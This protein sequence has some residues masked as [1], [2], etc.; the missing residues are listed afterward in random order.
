MRSSNESPVLMNKS[1]PRVIL[2]QLNVPGNIPTVPLAA[3]YLKAMAFKAGLFQDVDI[4]VLSGSLNNVAGDS[5]VVSYILEK[6]PQIIGFSCYVWNL[7]RSLSIINQIKSRLPKVR[8]ICGGTEVSSQFRKIMFNRNIDI[9]ARGEGE[10]TFVEL[11]KNSLFNIPKLQ[12]IKGIVFRENG[13]M[14]VTAER[15]QIP[16]VNIIPSP[17]LLGFIDTKEYGKIM[18]E[19]YRGCIER[20]SYCN[21]RR[22][23]R[24]IRYF[25]E[26]RIKDEIRLAREKNVECDI[27]DT[28]FNLPDNLTRLSKFI[29]EINYDKH[30]K[31]R[32]EGRAEFINKKTIGHLTKCNVVHINIGLQ[33]TNQIALRNVNRWFN[34]ELFIRGI[35]L[36]KKAKIPFRLDLIIGLPGDGL[37]SIKEGIRFVAKY[38]KNERNYFDILQIPPDVELRRQAKKFKLKYLKTQPYYV[39]STK[40]ISHREF[41]KIFFML[42]D[43]LNYGVNSNSSY[44]FNQLIYFS[45]EDYKEISDGS[46]SPQGKDSIVPCNI[47]FEID[48]TKQDIKQIEDLAIN[49]RSLISLYTNIYFKCFPG[50]SN[51]YFI[52]RF[53]HLIS[54]TNDFCRFN[55]LLETGRVFKNKISGIRDSISIRQVYDDYR[56]EFYMKLL[57]LKSG[58]V[59]NELVTIRPLAAKKRIAKEIPVL[60]SISVSE[61]DY[62]KK[63][64]LESLIGSNSGILIDF[65]PKSSNLSLCADVLKYISKHKRSKNPVFFRNY[66]LQLFYNEVLLNKTPV[67]NAVRRLIGTCHDIPYKVVYINSH[68]K[69]TILVYNVPKAISKFI[70]INDTYE[71]S[72]K[73]K[74]RIPEGFC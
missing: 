57:G 61:G 34:K 41:K 62:W 46:L 27:I 18:M 67:R 56:Q 55:V 37:A 22:D 64:L 9:I 40:E 10:L 12:E 47:V 53:L 43:H 69:K 48:E 21:W 17:Y 16:D 6:Q 28:I 11:V 3:G 54:K 73:Q 58:F 15:E 33:S 7:E 26:E 68:L 31:F 25:A 45:Q 72:I 2:S 52:N 23:F 4:D 51:F 5:N 35:N 20:C 42:R 63:I 59:G 14:V 30:M 13:K 49:L 44:S 19:T 60:S 70:D 66:V 1:K 36:L 32:V 29:E 8:I 65:E 38:N 39:L 50:G 71:R 24:G 74:G